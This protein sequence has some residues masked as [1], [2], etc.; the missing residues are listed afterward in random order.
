MN[1]VK[2]EISE[3]WFFWKLRFLKREF[4]E[5]WYFRNVNF[6]KI[7]I[8]NFRIKCVSTD[9]II[10]VSIMFLTTGWS[11]NSRLMHSL[12]SFV[13][14]NRWCSREEKPK[15]PKLRIEGLSKSRELK[16]LALLKSLSCIPL[17]IVDELWL[18]EGFSCCQNTLEGNCW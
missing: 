3:M 15:P 4:C 17:S 11:L 8:L 13:W 18:Y 10:P 2:I 9:L 16:I 6:V 5:N 12:D 1:F 14:W 7:G